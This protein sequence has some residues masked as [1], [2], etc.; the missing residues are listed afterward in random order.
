MPMC[1]FSIG[2]YPLYLECSEQN[3]RTFRF[4]SGWW[5]VPSYGKNR[6]VQLWSGNDEHDSIYWV[7]SEENPTSVGRM[8]LILSSHNHLNSGKNCSPQISSEH[9]NPRQRLLLIQTK[10]PII[11][12]LKLKSCKA[13]Q[14]FTGSRGLWTH[15]LYTKVEYNEIHIYKYISI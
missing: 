5:L 14:E 11:S 9:D 8:L 10:L 3:S 7:V 4:E 6:M 12:G 13:Q 15:Q 1:I 2:E